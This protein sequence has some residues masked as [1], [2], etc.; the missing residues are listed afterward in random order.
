MLLAGA[1]FLLYPIDSTPRVGSD[2][3]TMATVHKGS[4]LVHVDGHGKINS[5]KQQVITSSVE[6]MVQEVK[7]RPGAYIKK[8]DVIV[9]SINYKIVKKINDIKRSIAIKKTGIQ[10]FILSTELTVIQQES[11]QR[12]IKNE[13][14]VITTK[15]SKQ[16][17]LMNKGIV[18]E[19]K[20]IESK[21][22][23]TQLSNKL[24]LMS[25]KKDKT[26]QINTLKL[27]NKRVLL[28]QLVDDL[29]KA[30]KDL[31]ALTIRASMD[32]IIQEL[33]L[34]NGQIIQPNTK[35]GLI[36]SIDD[37][38]VNLKVHQTKRNLIKKNQTISVKATSLSSVHYDG[39]ITRIAPKTIDGYVVVEAKLNLPTGH[40]LFP[41]QD[42]TG[43]IVVNQLMQTLFVDIPFGVT[44]NKT[45][46]IFVTESEFMAK[47]KIIEFGLE[48]D[49]KIQIHNGVDEG[50]TV[51]ISNTKE[52]AS[53]D[54]I[55]II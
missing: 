11:E 25:S 9:T 37:L 31:N 45:M 47:M 48:S 23:S 33:D 14:D 52:L 20:F 18:S 38:V 44:P 30:E 16:E 32:G 29:E 22:R 19:M 49:G 13:L 41:S 1:I 2:R 12:N 27:T 10:E 24:H 17:G 8:G 4:M 42:V 39:I 35:L 26:K 28:A 21:L 15:L 54:V 36:G 5:N 40:S 43:K 6:G 46:S 7:L 3:L 55:Q 50:D 34:N 53:N 51:I